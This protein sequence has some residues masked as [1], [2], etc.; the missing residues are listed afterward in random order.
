M[1][2]TKGSSLLETRHRNR[3]LIKKMI[4]QMDEVTRTQIATELG[5]TLP[6]IT[7]SVNDMMAEG[8]IEEIPYS[9][10][11]QTTAVGRK[12][13]AL[14]FASNAACAIGVELGPY[15][16]YAALINLNGEVL[17][18]IE[19]EPVK[20]YREMLELVCSMVRNLQQYVGSRRFLGVG[21]G[22][23]GFIESESGVIR[24]N[25]YEEWT[26]KALAEDM[27]GLLQVPVLLDNNVRVRAVGYQMKNKGKKPDILA[28][29]FVSRGIACPLMIQDE[30]LSGHVSGAGEL[31]QSAVCSEINGARVHR[32]VNDMASEAA[33]LQS[34]YKLAEEGRSEYLARILA[35]TGCIKIKDVLAAQRQGDSEVGYVLER[36]IEYLGIALSSVVNLVNPEVVVVDSTLM[37]NEK[38][39]QQLV[40][41]AKA[42][43]FGLNEEEVQILF[44][45]KDRFSGAKGAAYHVIKKMLLEA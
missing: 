18:E 14:A 28:Y 24:S 37:E 9:L 26:G 11:E 1:T 30:V 44:Q 13:A 35:E 17:A 6:T 5:L 22:L 39:R 20:D 3:V 31:G 45:P 32:T 41:A 42:C 23:P 2:Q 8:L 4:F 19:E 33:I 40:Q 27:E 7:T 34:S 38:N 12:P 29:L 10:N 25:P 15:A 16:T 36:A 43:F 21:V